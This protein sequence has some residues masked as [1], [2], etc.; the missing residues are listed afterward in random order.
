MSPDCGTRAPPT[1]RRSRAS[2]GAA[3]RSCPERG[4][5]RRGAGRAG[6]SRNHCRV[7]TRAG[8]ARPDSPFRGRSTTPIAGEA[9]P[10]PS[11]QRRG[12]RTHPIARRHVSGRATSRTARATARSMATA[13]RLPPRHSREAAPRADATRSRSARPGRRLAPGDVESDGAARA[14]P[15]RAAAAWPGNRRHARDGPWVLRRRAGG[16]VPP[17][18][19]RAGRRARTAGRCCR[20]SRGSRDAFC[21]PL[22]STIGASSRHACPVVSRAA[23]TAARSGSST[24]R[25]APSNEYA[26]PC[27]FR[28]VRMKKTIGPVPSLRPMLWTPLRAPSATTEYGTRYR[29]RRPMLSDA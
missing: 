13:P 6:R 19:R 29:S 2:P 17:G 16:S 21:T 28:S 10:P 15:N 11:G 18:A 25:V 3:S 4:P 1:A 8:T 24:C 27:A 12:G 7:T 5:G 23:R 22:E 26:V 9:A 20:R 14:A